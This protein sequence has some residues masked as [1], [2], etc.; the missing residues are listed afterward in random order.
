MHDKWDGS[1]AKKEPPQFFKKISIVMDI[2]CTWCDI[3]LSLNRKT[4][5]S[6]RTVD[7]EIMIWEVKICLEKNVQMLL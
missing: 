3:I 1:F 2:C 5:D 6:L 4:I 7:Q